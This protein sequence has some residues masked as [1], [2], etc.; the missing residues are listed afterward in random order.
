MDNRKN[1]FIIT[2]NNYPEGDAGAIRQHAFS[3]NIKDLGYRPIIIGMGKTT[4]FKKKTN[5]SLKKYILNEKLKTAEELLIYSKYRYS[6]IAAFL[7]FCS[8]S[9]LG[10]A[11]QEKNGMTLRE[12]QLRWQK[13]DDDDIF[14]K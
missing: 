13:S 1:F 3:K 5:I 11:F 2:W 14:I 6:D 7:G 4:K 12:Y 9:H 10:K 8:Q